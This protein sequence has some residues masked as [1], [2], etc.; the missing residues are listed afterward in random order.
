M[1]VPAMNVSGTSTGFGQWSA[2][3]MTPAAK[4]ATHLRRNSDTSLFISKE[5]SAICCSRQKAK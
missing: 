1:S 5:L 3:K 2:A 4:L